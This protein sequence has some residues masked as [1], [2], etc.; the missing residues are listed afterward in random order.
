M[1]RPPLRALSCLLAAGLALHG[2]PL[3]AANT[4]SDAMVAYVA[5]LQDDLAATPEIWRVLRLSG[6]AHADLSQDDI[7]VLDRQWRD[8]VALSDRPIVAT[9]LDN[10]ASD[11]LRAMQEAA[12]GQLTEIIVM[13][14]VGLNAAISA[15]TSDFW[16]GDEA[17]HSET[18]GRPAGT[19]HVGEVEFDESSQTYQVQVSAP[20]TDPVT[21]APLGAVTFGLNAEMF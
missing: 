11:A 4:A 9:V 3:A 7:L 1:L 17:K 15:V 6:S 14:T 20:L 16:Q 12:A 10:P 8:Q 19:L 18:F 5:Q 13:D 2:A 21:G